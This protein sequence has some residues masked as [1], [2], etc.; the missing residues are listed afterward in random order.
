VY[1]PECFPGKKFGYFSSDDFVG[2]E[3]I[4]F[5]AAHQ[6]DDWIPNRIDLAVNLVSFQEMT[7]FQVRN[8]SEQ[9]IKKKTLV[10]YSHNKQKSR[11]NPEI[12]SVNSHFKIWPAAYKQEVL[13][14]DYSGALENAGLMIA[15]RKKGLF[16]KVINATIF[17][18]RRLPIK[19]Y[20]GGNRVLKLIL[21]PAL[22]NYIMSRVNRNYTP[23]RYTHYF[24]Y[25]NLEISNTEVQSS[26]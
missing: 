6:F 20:D 23:D 25:S 1:L 26:D 5:I 14:W 17:T 12:T 18:L 21:K 2:D 8:Y 13:D 16:G 3:D 9:L 22:Y 10:T 24:F 4:I 7:D 15:L 11:N 19:A